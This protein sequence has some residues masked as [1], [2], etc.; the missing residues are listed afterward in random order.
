VLI[1]SR[2][3]KTPHAAMKKMLGRLASTQARILG[4][5]INEF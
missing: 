4:A 5:V 2:A 3:A 1:C